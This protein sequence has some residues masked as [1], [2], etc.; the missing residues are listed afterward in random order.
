MPVLMC[1]FS[2]A[3]SPLATLS[4]AES[5][6]FLPTPIL[7]ARILTS[8]TAFTLPSTVMVPLLLRGIACHEA[9]SVVI[10]VMWAIFS[11]AVLTSASLTTRCIFS[12]KS[13]VGVITYS[14]PVLITPDLPTAIPSWLRKNRLPPIWLF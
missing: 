2:A 7:A 9:A 11:A 6:T 3:I 1:A 4:T 10:L 5:S 12:I 8:L 13:C 14:E